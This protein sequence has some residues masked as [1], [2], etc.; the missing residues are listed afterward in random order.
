MAKLNLEA[1]TFQKELDGMQSLPLKTSSREQTYNAQ[2]IDDLWNQLQES[3]KPKY[4]S[5]K[6]HREKMDDIDYDLLR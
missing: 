4:Q 6:V 3:T 2:Q 5:A 1:H